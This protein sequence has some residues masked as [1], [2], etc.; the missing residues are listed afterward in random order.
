MPV[1]ANNATDNEFLWDGMASFEGGMVSNA[2]ASGLQPNQSALIYNAYIHITGQLRKRRGISE[3]TVPI[4]PIVSGKTIQGL[5]WFDT[6]TIDKLLAAIDGKIYAYDQPTKTWSVYINASITNLDEQV[7]MVQLSDDLFWT[8]ST[9]AGIRKWD[10]GTLAITTVAGPLNATILMSVSLRL[11]AAGMAAYPS[12]LWF[13]DYLDGN[14]WPATQ[15]IGIGEDGD[16]ITCIKKWQKHFLIVGKYQS[17]Y[18]VD[19]NPSYGKVAAFPVLEIHPSV[20]CTAKRS[21]CQVGQDMFFLSRNGVMKV[22]PQDA[23]DTNVLI[24]LPVS[25]PIQDYIHRIRWPI[26]YKS[27]ACCYNN[28]YLL[29]VPI[30]SN[31]PDTLLVYSYITSSWV[32]VWPHQDVIDFCEQP[33]LGATR[34]IIGCRSGRVKEHRDYIADNAELE[35]DYEDDTVPVET[36]IISRSMIFQEAM[37]AKTPFYVE[38]EFFSKTGWIEVY[39]MLDGGA[40]TLLDDGRFQLISAVTLP[41]YLPVFLVGPKWVKKKFPIFPLGQFREIQIKVVGTDGNL[42]LRSMTLSAQ[43]DSVNFNKQFEF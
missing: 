17:I 11:A 26:A 23:T 2:K 33:Y 31:E 6:P 4:G 38:V 39:A 27:C 13:S 9:K 19:A 10:S 30:N 25:Q 21:M 8:D 18:Y 43:L 35:I 1:F 40:A 34:L 22:T 41:F 14:S 29:S 20:G 12:T 32:G 15:A 36:V 16:P 5:K 24:P 37:S 3:I 42:I 28:H 7:S